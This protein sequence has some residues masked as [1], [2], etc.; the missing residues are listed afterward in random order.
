MVTCGSGCNF[1]LAAF[2]ACVK[3]VWRRAYCC[4]WEWRAELQ[5][6]HFTSTTIKLHTS[7]SSLS[8][9]LLPK[10]CEN[11]IDWPKEFSRNN[12]WSLIYLKILNSMSHYKKG[13]SLSNP[14]ICL[15]ASTE[16]SCNLLW[17]PSINRFQESL[18][19]AAFMARAK[20][21]TAHIMEKFHL[22]YFGHIVDA[23]QSPQL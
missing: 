5:Q 14:S 12:I 15:Q 1:W 9:F 18:L 8:S 19:E 6:S 17:Q 4:N 2:A 3:V 21:W 20:N 7:T 10:N 23:L 22:R 11:D 16:V 13:R